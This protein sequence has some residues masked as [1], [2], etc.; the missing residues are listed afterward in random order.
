M[1]ASRPLVAFSM[2]ILWREHLDFASI[3]S[4]DLSQYLLAV[5]RNNPRVSSVY[6]HLHPAVLHEIARTVGKAETLGLPL[7]LCGEMSSD[8]AAVILLVGMGIRRLSMSAARLPQI[9]WLIRNIDTGYAR[10]LLAEVRDL[11]DSSTIRDTMN[12]HLQDLRLP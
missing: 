12:R 9:K 6:D 7:S 8:P 3:G 4:N 10:R 1:S 11:P 2:S 5:D